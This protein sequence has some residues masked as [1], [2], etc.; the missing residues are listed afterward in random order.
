ML[1]LNDQDLGRIEAL[2]ANVIEA[3]KA[4]IF[5]KPKVIMAGAR[6]MLSALTVIFSRLHALEQ[7]A[8]EN[9][10]TD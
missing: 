2:S 10:E 6:L 9:V 3:D 7:K 8:S 5:E 4:P 1:P